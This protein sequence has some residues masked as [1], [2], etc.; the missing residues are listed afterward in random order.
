MDFA[1]NNLIR[2]KVI[3]ND[4]DV[5]NRAMSIESYERTPVLNLRSLPLDTPYAHITKRAFDIV[6]SSVV[7]L[8]VLSWLTPILYIIIKAES[9]GSLFF[10]QLRHGLKRKT[11]WCYKFRSMT[12]SSTANQEMACK[13]D[14]RA[15]KFGKFMRKTSLDELPQFFNVFMGEMS[16]I[17]PR[18]HMVVHTEDFEKSVDKYLVRHFVKP[19]ITGLAQIKGYRGEILAPEDIKNRTRMDIFYVE[20]WSPGLDLEILHGTFLNLFKKEEKAY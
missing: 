20:K 16:V 13:N 5:F 18:P 1:D 8:F 6:F 11:F 14:M 9:P 3:L 17:G 19:G 7:I 15:T 2:F 10:K 4:M 12:V